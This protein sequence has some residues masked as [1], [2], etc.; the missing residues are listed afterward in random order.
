MNHRITFATFNIALAVALGALGAH[1]LKEHLSADSLDSFETG[2][3]YHLFHGLALLVIPCLPIAKNKLKTPWRIM[4][5]GMILFSF[6]IY[7]LSTRSLF[8]LE[9]GLRWLGPITPLGG[10]LLILSWLWISFI[11]TFRI[12]ELA[13]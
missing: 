1:F 5:L 6:S 2:V 11:S 10:I 4:A 3:R 13:E 8:G 7:G 9:S 12:R